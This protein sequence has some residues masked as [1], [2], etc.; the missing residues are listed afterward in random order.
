MTERTADEIK[1]LN[2]QIYQETGITI[3]WASIGNRPI[4]DI[5]AE[6]A[7][8]VAKRN[9]RAGVKALVA[10]YGPASASRIVKRESGRTIRETPRGW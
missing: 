6:V 7:Q 4:E 1:A 8:L 10:K 5:N 2:K 9:K 3:S